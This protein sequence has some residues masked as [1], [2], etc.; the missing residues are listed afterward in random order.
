MTAI[1]IQ[2]K[3]RAKRVLQVFM[4]RWIRHVSASLVP[5]DPER[6]AFR[7]LNKAPYIV[8]FFGGK[9]WKFNPLSISDYFEAKQ[10]VMNDSNYF[11]QY[12]SQKISDLWD[13]M[14]KD[15]M[16]GSVEQYRIVHPDNA[17]ES[18]SL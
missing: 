16:T 3:Q 9:P 5:D 4:K 7:I 14:C 15:G 10:V 17:Q 12:L 18:I 11:I 2:Q 8:L 1:D 13:S 6:E